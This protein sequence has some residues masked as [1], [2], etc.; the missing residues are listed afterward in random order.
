MKY[1]KSF[2]SFSQ[3]VE[4]NQS[5]VVPAYN[6][7]RNIQMEEFVDRII[8]SGNHEELY[9]ILNFPKPDNLTGDEFDK[10]FDKLKEVAIEFF[11]KDPSRFNKPAD[12]ESFLK[13]SG[14]G[15]PRTNKVGGTSFTNS[16]RIGQ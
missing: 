12:F 8:K 4:P 16:P 3:D 10:H 6:P 2:E 9:K 5:E 1:L 7:V 11:S 13:P 14:D 15:I